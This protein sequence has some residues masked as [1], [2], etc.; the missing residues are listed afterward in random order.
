[1]DRRQVVVSRHRGLTP[2][3]VL[4]LSLVLSAGVLAGCGDDGGSTAEPVAL[5]AA[6]ERG[7]RV[8][9]EQGCTSC[10]ST[11]G[12]RG[13]GPTWKDLAGSEVELDGGTVIADDDYLRRAIVDP[14]SEVVRGYA[15]IMP[16]YEGQ[17]SDEEL[18]DLIAYLRDLSVNTAG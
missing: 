16:V 17:M 3:V 8:A 10:H 9:S 2:A 1:M 15:N 6:G 13:T 18:D 11:D 7:A 14:R 5:S 4:G 12:S